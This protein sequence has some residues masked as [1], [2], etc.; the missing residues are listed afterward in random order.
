[1]NQVDG[2]EEKNRK[3]NKDMRTVMRK[4]GVMEIDWT[5]DQVGI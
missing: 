1:M 5:Y 2:N 4:K 3:R